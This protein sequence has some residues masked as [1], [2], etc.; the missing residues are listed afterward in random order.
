[1]F[2]AAL[3]EMI[4]ISTAA[5]RTVISGAGRQVLQHARPAADVHLL[6]RRA[7]VEPEVASLQRRYTAQRGPAP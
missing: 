2:V 6:V 7:L 3:S 4:I 1:M 5:S